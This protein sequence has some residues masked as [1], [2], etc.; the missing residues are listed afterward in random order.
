M[1]CILTLNNSSLDSSEFKNFIDEENIFENTYSVYNYLS[2]CNNENSK[3]ISH[4]K[5]KFSS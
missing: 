1:R 4:V 3:K 2:W 5:A